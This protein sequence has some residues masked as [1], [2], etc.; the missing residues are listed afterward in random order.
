MLTICGLISLPL[1]GR[2]TNVLLLPIP[3]RSRGSHFF[4]LLIVAIAPSLCVPGVRDNACLER[5]KRRKQV[6]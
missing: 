3:S 2:K 1:Y 5:R 6:Y 4:G